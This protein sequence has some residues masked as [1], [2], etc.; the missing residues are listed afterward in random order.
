MLL[1]GRPKCSRACWAAPKAGVFVTAPQRRPIVV[2]TDMLVTFT[3]TKAKAVPTNA[4]AILHR[5]SAT[6]SCRSE[7]KKLGPTY[8]PK[9]YTKRTKPNVSA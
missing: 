4:T 5:F 8:K 6:P 9:V 2:P 3:T 1:V 7:P